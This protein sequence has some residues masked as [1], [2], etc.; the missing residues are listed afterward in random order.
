MRSPRRLL[1]VVI[2]GVL[3]VAGAGWVVGTR[4]RSPADEA[5]RRAAPKPSLVTAAVERRRLVSTLVVNGTLEYGSPLPVGLAGA[6]GGASE[7]Q[8][9]TRAPRPGR[10]AEGGVLMEVNGRPVFVLRGSVPMHRTI[11]PGSEGDDVAQVQRALRR[12]GHRA[13]ATG[14][15]DPATVAALTRLYAAKGYQAQRPAL[16][17]R[18]TYETLRKAVRT[19]KET[20]AAEKQALDRGRDVLPLKLRLKNAR[21]GLTAA[22]RALA[23]ARSEELP[24]A[25]EARLSAADSAV[26][27]AEERL[28]EAE[29]ALEAA[30]TRPTTAPT[31]APTAAATGTP[32]P[33]GTAALQPTASPADT[34]LLE[35]RVANARADLSAAQEAR[36]LIVKEAGQTRAARIEQLR[37]AVR[38]AQET[39]ATAEQALRQARQLSPARL[40]VTGARADVA[41]AEEMLAEYSRTYGV[42]IPPG[43]VVFLPKL[44]ARVR[45]VS[46]KAGQRVEGEVATVTSSSFAVTASVEAAES[47]LLRAG[48]P[49]TVELDTGRSYPAR[50][51]AV[52]DKA[53][54][55]GSAAVEGGGQPVLITPGPAKGLKAGTAVTARITVGATKDPV[56]VVP[57]AAVITSAD[58]RARVRVEYAADRTRDVEVRTGLSADGNVEVT[59]ALKEGDRVV[60][61]DA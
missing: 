18:Q 30:R 21:T 28:L 42:S 15:F 48:M 7:L 23:E 60:V 29:Q 49:A 56:L 59:G 58:G 14:V 47:E 46:V 26:R 33:T 53:K 19:A 8:R 24:P 44:P 6:V 2:A 40:K 22:R 39:L 27:A 10:I 1:A 13:P 35:L 43:E 17:D 50:L 41:A 45:K 57:V 55:P 36:D 3:I 5:A 52:G 54:V 20:L 16:A 4:L 51:T 12:L 9:A 11:T 25:D 34:R 38:T 32:A 31:S 37:A 61:G